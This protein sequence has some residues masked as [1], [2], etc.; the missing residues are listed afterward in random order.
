MQNKQY[1]FRSKSSTTHAMFDV[2][3]GISTNMSKN[4]YSGL[5]FLDWKKAFDAVSQPILRGREK[6]K[7]KHSKASRTNQSH[8][9]TYQFDQ[10]PCYLYHEFV[11]S[12]HVVNWL[13]ASLV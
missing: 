10:Q 2:I 4:Q 8:K 6:F 1:G 5:I 11:E 3:D 12:K 7:R 13:R 9:Y